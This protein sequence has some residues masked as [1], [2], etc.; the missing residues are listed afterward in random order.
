MCRNLWDISEIK[1]VSKFP[2]ILEISFGKNG[3]FSKIHVIY[4]SWACFCSQ[5]LFQTLYH[6]QII[7]TDLCCLIFILVD[8]VLFG[9]YLHILYWNYK[10]I[11]LKKSLKLSFFCRENILS[12]NI[13]LRAFL[14]VYHLPYDSQT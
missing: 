8:R 14:S 12:K 1:Y 6:Y 13:E 3:T 2:L 5:K 4:I 11:L 7:N 10:L 9:N